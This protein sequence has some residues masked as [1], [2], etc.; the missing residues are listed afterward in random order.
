MIYTYAYPRP[1]VTVDIIVFKKEKNDVQILL[2]ER[3]NHPFK[4]MW[5]LPGGFVDKDEDIK[6]AAYRELAE[7]TSIQDIQLSQLHTFGKPGRDPRGHTVSVVYKGFLINSNQKIKA[8]DDAK[9]LQW[10]SI[11][12]LP[13]LAF[14]HREII[15]YVVASVIQ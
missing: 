2:I 12:D 1:A 8:G 9:N 7:E 15:E 10:F 14:D 6:I 11:N 4:N 13:D 3:K 5:A